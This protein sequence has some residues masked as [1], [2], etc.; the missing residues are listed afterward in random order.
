MKKKIV[1][2]EDEEDILLMLEAILIMQG[3]DVI[4]DCTGRIFDNMLSDFPDLVILDVNLQYLDGRDICKKIKSNLLTKDIP[5]IFISAINNLQT[6]TKVCGAD[7]YLSKPFDIPELAKKI[8][9]HLNAAEIL[10]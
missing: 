7:G 9:H 2:I 4:T 10:H 1:V 5:V 6:I 3:Y 8:Q